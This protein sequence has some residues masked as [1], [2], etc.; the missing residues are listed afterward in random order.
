ME[1]RTYEESQTP[2]HYAA[3]NGSV[4]SVISLIRDYGA[5]K[6]AKDHQGNL[7]NIPR[8]RF[9]ILRLIMWIIIKQRT[10]ATLPGSRTWTT[11]H[12]Q[13]V[14]RFGLY[15]KSNEQRGS[16]GPIL[17]NCQI[18]RTSPFV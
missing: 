15:R 10:N 7:V 9:I 12:T 18:A 3:K 4:Q 16:K 2:L 11:K 14:D 8:R 1:T 6:E 13:I 5:N 17:D